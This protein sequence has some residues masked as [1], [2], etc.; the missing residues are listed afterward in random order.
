[1]VIF[2]SAIVSK[3]L[4]ETEVSFQEL[5]ALYRRPIYNLLYRLSGSSQ[6]AEDLTQEVFMKA[7]CA[8]GRFRKDSSHY[9]WLYRIAVNSFRDY[10]RQRTKGQYLS[11]EPEGIYSVEGQLEQ[12]ELEATVAD[13]ARPAA[14]CGGAS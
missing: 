5:V 13:V 7:F 14:P 6:D 10:L 1:M 12:K 11:A 3:E 2:S 8:Y 9:T 4:G